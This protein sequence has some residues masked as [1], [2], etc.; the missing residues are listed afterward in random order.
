MKKSILITDKTIL[1]QIEKIAYYDVE[2]FLRDAEAYIQAIKEGRMLCIIHS[3]SN[4]GMSR[5][6]S[7]HSCE[8]SKE[9]A[10]YRQ[11]YCLFVSLS[12]KEARGEKK[13]FTINGCGMDMVFHTNNSIISSFE[14]IGIISKEESETLRQQT[15]VVL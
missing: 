5:N 14:R 6:L 10:Y 13:G 11:Y 9:R 12:Y 3:V 15:P 4:S 1:K 8:I 7:F 2:N